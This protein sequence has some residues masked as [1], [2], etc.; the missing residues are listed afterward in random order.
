MYWRQ[1][2]DFS[3][4]LALSLSFCVFLSLMYFHPFKVPQ[5]T[6]L[7]FCHYVFFHQSQYSAPCHIFF[8]GTSFLLQSFCSRDSSAVPNTHS[9]TSTLEPKQHY[10]SPFVPS[11]HYW[12]THSWWLEAYFIDLNSEN[13][14]LTYNLLT[15]F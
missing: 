10:A 12:I 4:F 13:F 15:H 1:K 14:F 6:L 3:Q 11:S 7:Y 9:Y 5:N 8:W 2:Q